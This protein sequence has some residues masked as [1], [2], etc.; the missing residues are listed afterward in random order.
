MYKAHLFIC[1][2]GPDK[3]GK[4]GNKDSD[5][6]IQKVKEYFKENK[7][8]DPDVKLRINKSG[9][10]GQCD[11]GIACVLY[12]QNQW[13]LDLTKKDDEVLINAVEQ[14]LQKK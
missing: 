1:N 2:N 8:T 12:P 10:L 11:R 13:F 6:L 5:E 3:K 14:A 9:C 4:C 7:P